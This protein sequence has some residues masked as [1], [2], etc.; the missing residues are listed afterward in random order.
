MPRSFICRINVRLS[1]PDEEIIKSATTL[2]RFWG[3]DDDWVPANLN[4]AVAEILQWSD[5]PAI[6]GV[7][8]LG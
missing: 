7:E 8:V 6:C 4:E 1:E 5:A 3:R 2:G